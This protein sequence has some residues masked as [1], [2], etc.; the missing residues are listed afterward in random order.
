VTDLPEREDPV[1]L[2]AVPVITTE[3][4]DKVGLTL[5][6]YLCRSPSRATVE[7]WASEVSQ[8]SQDQVE[9][10]L[11]TAQAFYLVSN[12]E[13]ED[14]AR[15]W[16]IGSDPCLPDGGPS[17]AIRNGDRRSVLSAAWHHVHDPEEMG[18]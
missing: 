16:L 14:I 18:T 3:M 10:L 6:A 7:D 5:L 11:I 15:A 1:H 13:G 9:R 17:E 8:P 4:I 12:D 2:D